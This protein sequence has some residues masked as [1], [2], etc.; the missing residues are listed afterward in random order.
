MVDKELDKLTSKNAKL[1]ALKENICMRVLGLGWKDLATLWSK[2]G[3][4][5]TPNQLTTHLKN[6]VSHQRTRVIPGKPLV[7]LPKRKILPSLGTK[8]G[9]VSRI[10][11]RYENQPEKF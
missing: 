11:Q 7:E 9:T 1:N 8:T 10:E 4:E 2:N 6:N 3:K 5:F